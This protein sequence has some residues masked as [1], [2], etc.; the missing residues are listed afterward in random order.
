MSLIHA[1]TDYGATMAGRK[2]ITHEVGMQPLERYEMKLLFCTHCHDV[3]RLHP[4][5]RRCRCGRSWG[6]YLEDRA[7]TVQ[8]DRS[9]SL[10]L[11]NPDVYAAIE[12]FFKQPDH[13]SPEL[14]IRCWI[15]PISE[16]DVT[17]IEEETLVQVE[18]TA[19]QTPASDGAASQQ[20]IG[21]EAS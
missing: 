8:T 20:E 16:N 4:E 13:F 7:T 12:L 6:R 19:E 18:P 5:P 11:A 21:T 3:V 9:I 2:R 10:G 1:I 14:S 17:F 15:N